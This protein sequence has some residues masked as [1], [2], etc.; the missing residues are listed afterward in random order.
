MLI[1]TTETIEGK[2][3]EY[4]GLVG[5]W[6]IN[7]VGGM[8]KLGDKLMVKTMDELKASIEEA[9][10]PMGADAVVGLKVQFE[11]YVTGVGTA[12]RFV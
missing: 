10:V 6:C 7:N 9:A 8:K 2:K 3:L 12:V 4:I 1:T 11:K 5:G